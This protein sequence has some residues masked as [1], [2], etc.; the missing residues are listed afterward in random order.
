MKKE[1]F[2]CMWVFVSVVYLVISFLYVVE[3]LRNIKTDNLSILVA[4]FLFTGL[5]YGLLVSLPWI[6]KALAPKSVFLIILEKMISAYPLISRWRRP[7][8][9]REML[10][11][12][13]FVKHFKTYLAHLVV[14]AVACFVLFGPQ[15]VEFRDVV[16]AVMRAL[17]SLIIGECLVIFTRW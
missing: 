15:W 2:V 11:K 4:G 17:F 8:N 3:G 10:T 9:R 16:V 1:N 14:V 7:K 5:L 6:V 12:K 13:F